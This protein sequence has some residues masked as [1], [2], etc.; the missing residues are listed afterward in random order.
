MLKYSIISFWEG[1]SY[2]DNIFTNNFCKNYLLTT[3]YG[4]ADFIIIG[5]FINEDNYNIIKLLNCKKILFITEPFEF[6]YKYTYKLYIEEAFNCLVGSIDNSLKWDRYKYPLY[7]L[8]TNPSIELFESINNYVKNCN[9]EDKDFCCLINRHDMYN[10]RTNIYNSLKDINNIKCPSSL[11]NNCSNNELNQIGNVEYIKKFK[12]NICPENCFT[13]I[14]GYI[15]EKLLNCCLAG[16]IPI[17]FGWFDD[18]DEKIFNK[19]RILFYDPNNLESIENIKN[20]ILFLLENNEEFN[21]FYKQDVFHENAFET[22]NLLNNN[23]IKM[24]NNL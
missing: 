23:L 21:I 1:Y 5:C 24:F 14:N 10:T 15:T 22:I 3:N 8:Y 7:I 17:Y 9:I 12:F 4:E 6:F 16:S 2:I 19:N 20:K 11:F 13:N 18:I